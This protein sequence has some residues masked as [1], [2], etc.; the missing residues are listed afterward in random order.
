MSREKDSSITVGFVA[1]GCPK[2]I[3]DSERMLAEIAQAGYVITTEPESADVVVINTCG[4]IAPAKDEALEAIRQAV[5]WK[6]GGAVE[7]VIVAGCLV[8]RL[9]LE[10]F[11]QA[12]GVD[13]IVGL[14]QRDD[15]GRII[16]K[17][18]ISDQGTA[19]LA[20]PCGAI[21]TSVPKLED[22]SLK[23]Y[24]DRSRLLITPSHYAYLRISEGCNHRCSFCTVPAIRGRFRSKPQEVILAEAVEL[25]SAGVVELNM[26]A[27]DT[28]YYGRDVKIKNALPTL[29]KELETIAD[30]K[31]IRLMYAYPAGIIEELVETIAA[32]ERIVNYL[33][34]PV[35]HINDKIL[36]D[37]RRPDSKERICAL[38]EKL[39]SAVPDIVLRTT[40]IVGFPGETEEQF[41]ELL[42]FTEW[43]R[44]DALGCFKYY[45]ESGTPAAEMPGQIS[46]R[47]KEDR[48]EEL[49]L[50]QQKIAFAKNKERV[51]SKLTC[52]VD[53]V[54]AGGTATGRFY[55]QAPDID[56]VC[57]IENCSAKPGEFITAKV[58]GT[59][60][61]DL[62]VEQI[63]S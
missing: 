43:A 18:L 14:G 50:T 5:A 24:D 17:T 30:L 44:F 52:L 59:R 42:E 25:V 48:V 32:S 19:Y 11:G 1:L 13:A 27:Q 62:V 35:Q 55:G 60:D 37:M 15:I 22:E 49:M 39:R 26:I 31:W 9:G 20:Q 53:S 34:M 56:S 38:I 21:A 33:D 63:S 58:I 6:A 16:K 36:K 7:R 40:L 47:T 10:L 12:D 45:P 3:V 61:Y 2:N 41:S 4:F 51:G 8:E 29:L 57:I 28:T 54:A 23:V 46:D